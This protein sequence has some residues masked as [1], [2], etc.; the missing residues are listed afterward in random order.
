MSC[1]LQRLRQ[2]AVHASSLLL[3]R[4]SKTRAPLRALHAP[5][6]LQELQ[7]NNALYITEDANYD[8][9]EGLVRCGATGAA[10]GFRS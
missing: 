4:R 5:E 8:H 3:A 2:A 9:A 10:V 1:A 7:E 6:F